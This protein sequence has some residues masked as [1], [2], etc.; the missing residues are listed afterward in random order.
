MIHVVLD[1][2]IY[3]QSPY[4]NS[5][6][7]KSLTN[8]AKRGN[9]CI[10]IPYVVEQEVSTNLAHDHKY[11]IDTAIKSISGIANHEKLKGVVP[12]IEKC[13]QELLKS[14]DDLYNETKDQFNEWLT[15]VGAARYDLSGTE[16]KNALDAYFCG[17]APLKSP[18]IR[19]HIPDSFIFQ[20][21][22]TLYEKYKD[23][24]HCI[25]H[26]DNLREACKSS[27]VET[28]ASLDEFITSEKIKDYLSN[29]LIV[30][31]MKFISEHISSYASEPQNKAIILS[32]IDLSLAGHPY[33][34][35]SD[36]VLG[37][38]QMFTIIDEHMPHS[39][40]YQGEIQHYGEGLF[41][42]SFDALAAV[43]YELTVS[44]DDVN[45]LDSNKYDI[46]DVSGC[47]FAAKT[48][49]EFKFSGRIEFDYRASFS[50]IKDKN[51]LLKALKEPE[52]SAIELCDFEI[53]DS[54]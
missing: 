53:N 34:V 41:V 1:S 48:T 43:T 33:M 11:K 54:K 21:I 14:K 15:E 27:G 37:E 49:D 19:K 44:R 51:E 10:H 46:R 22:Q 39:L 29:V 32:Q 38:N 5:P 16:T 40:E 52:I 50:A 30:E 2:N 12:G 24:L 45:K 47:W 13:L 18:K 7:F 9:I 23:R 6:E 26:D 8:L 17:K 20:S 35:I 3:L 25:I 31:N 4:L 42:L 36:S 28:H